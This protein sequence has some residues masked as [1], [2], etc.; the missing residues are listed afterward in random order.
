MCVAYVVWNKKNNSGGIFWVVWDKKKK[1]LHGIRRYYVPPH[2]VGRS[3]KKKREKKKRV[4]EA[5]NKAKQQQ[6]QKKK[7]EKVG[8]SDFV[9]F[10][11]V[12][13]LFFPLFLRIF[14][15]SSSAINLL[16]IMLKYF[17]LLFAIPKQTLRLLSLNCLPR[18]VQP[19]LV[20]CFCLR[21][22]NQNIWNAWA[23]R[24]RKKEKK[25]S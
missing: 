4:Q 10:S 25:M 19:P 1:W 3:A 24:E 8:R 13:F 14:D 18:T 22:Y 16:I 23:D 21:L 20:I 12:V 2:R 5:R 6:K 17:L 7:G 11:V 15:P 9:F